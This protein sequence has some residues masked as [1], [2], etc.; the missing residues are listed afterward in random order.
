MS[1]KTLAMRVLEGAK[2][3]YQIH[4]YPEDERDAEKIAQ[5]LDIPSDRVFKTLVVIRETGK[6]MLVMIPGSHQL[7]LKKLAKF[8]GEK[9]VKFATHAQAEQLTGL[10]VGGISPLVLLNRG[11]LILLDRSAVDHETVCVS[12]GKKGINLELDPH[13]LRQV[14][15]ARYLDAIS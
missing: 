4:T 8:L 14:S 5:Q 6:P 3:S 15:G 7:N 2:I 13:D 1:S 11:F 10:K 9:K 12:A